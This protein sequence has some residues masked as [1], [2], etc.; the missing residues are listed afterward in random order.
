[1]TVSA[2]GIGDR[3]GVFWSLPLSRM[4]YYSAPVTAEGRLASDTGRVSMD[5]YL[6]V[7]LGIVIAPWIQHTRDTP[8]WCRLLVI[9]FERLNKASMDAPWLTMITKA[10]RTYLDAT[11]VEQ[12]HLGKLLSLGMRHFQTSNF[13]QPT[14]P[15]F[16]LLDSNTLFAMI[17]DTE[18]TIQ[19]CRELATGLQEKGTETLIR[20]KVPDSTGVDRSSLVNGDLYFYASSTQTALPME[21]SKY[22]AKSSKLTHC[23]YAPGRR[24]VNSAVMN[25]SNQ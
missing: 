23:R 20:Y 2:H 21:R 6:I 5:E 11:G 10:A 8:R 4:R 24:K 19:L 14:S 1:V 17:K 22:S 15:L 3:V 16:G 12:Q 7:T 18:T 13:G 25:A 9:V